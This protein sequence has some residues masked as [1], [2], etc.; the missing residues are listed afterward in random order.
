MKD[1]LKIKKNIKKKEKNWTKVIK[2]N[3]Y[4]SRYN[5]II[6][7]DASFFYIWNFLLL[8]YVSHYFYNKMG[9]NNGF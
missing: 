7:I 1:E 8:D 2:K 3:S 6:F 4:Y 9:E 5:W